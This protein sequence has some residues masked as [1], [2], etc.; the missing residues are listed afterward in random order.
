MTKTISLTTLRKHRACDAYTTLFRMLFGNTRK[1]PVTPGV[2]EALAHIFDWDW[3]AMRLLSIKQRSL[4]TRRV[5]EQSS[6]LQLG[7]RYERSRVVR[8]ELCKKG[9]LSVDDNELLYMDSRV[10]YRKLNQLIQ[11]EAFALAFN[12]PR[13]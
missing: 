3:A 7:N 1:V 2:T 5:A 11:A 13:K 12:S 6:T 9:L 4:Y 8:Q 10:H